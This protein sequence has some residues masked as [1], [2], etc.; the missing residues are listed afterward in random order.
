[1]R[2]LSL[3]IACAALLSAEKQSFMLNINDEDL[4][5]GYEMISPIGAEAGLYYGVT[6]LRGADEY[7]KMRL[8]GAFHINAIGLTPINGLAAKIGIKA[9]VAQIEQSDDKDVYPFATPIGVGLIYTLPVA[10]K[11]H[12]SA[13]YDIAPTALCFNE[14]DRYTELRF[15][16]GIEPIEGGMVFGGWRKIELREEG[17]KY[18][19]NKAAYVGV[20]VSF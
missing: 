18:D 3:F 16:A 15:E 14:C 11:T 12:L 19:L 1:M 20:R 7:D 8:S 9:A 5:I 13:F 4:Q 6:A 2:K 17:W 10:I